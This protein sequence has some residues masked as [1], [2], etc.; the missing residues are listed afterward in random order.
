MSVPDKTYPH[1]SGIERAILGAM[2][3][4]PDCVGLVIEH[5]DSQDFYSPQ[6]A[7]VFTAVKSLYA[8]ND[9]ID[10]LTVTDA[11][12]KAGQLKLVGDEISLSN[13]YSEVAGSSGVTHHC[14][15][16]KDKYIKRRIITMCKTIE[17]E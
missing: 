5:I 2:L 6:N 14:R 3:V 15:I 8:S 11:L 17:A 7:M 12:D 4:D 10:Q 9:T 1:D 16:L 13:L